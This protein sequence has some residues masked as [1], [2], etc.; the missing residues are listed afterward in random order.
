MSM[1]PGSSIPGTNLP[2]I[3]FPGIASGIDY[4]SIISKLTSLTLAPT[5][6]LNQQVATLNAANAELIKI[7]GL[8]S[9]VQS[10]LNGLSMSAIY[11]AISATSSNTGVLTA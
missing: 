4:N 10:S 8:L 11:N 7:N 9:N 5:T 3:S 6:Q 1:S 2:P